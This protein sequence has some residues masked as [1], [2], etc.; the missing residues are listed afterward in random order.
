MI[1][2]LIGALM[3]VLLALNT[4]FWL[5]FVYGSILCKL[6]T[7]AGSAARRVTS[8]WV[9]TTCQRWALCNVWLAEVLLPTRWDIR[10]DTEVSNQGQYLICSNHQSWN[11]ILALIKAFGH[12]AP[13]FKFFLKQQLIWVPVLG[14]AWWGLDY[15]F[16]R[17]HTAAQI[18]RNPELKGRD[19]ETTRRACAR[20]KGQPSMVLNFLEGTRFTKA[21]HDA[22]KSPFQHLLKP[23]AG[24]FAFALSALGDQILAVL[25]ATVVY[26]DGNHG[27]WGFLCGRVSRVIVE[28]RRVEVPPA[29]RSGD[30]ENDPEFRKQFQQWI[31]E[32]WHDKD[33]LIDQLLAETTAQAT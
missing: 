23:R 29:M 25:D 20:Y 13:F 28:I 12:D 11:D 3:F 9:A 17:R 26:P 31:N 24:G 30:Y 10:L 19:I 6:L 1:R 7:P 16:M 4:L 27:L 14:L 32:V 18:A 2:L 8:S 21:K 15:P 5:P 22:Q 33:R